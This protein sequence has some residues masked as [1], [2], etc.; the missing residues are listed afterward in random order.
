V[1]RVSEFYGIAIYMYLDEHPPPHFHARYGGKW[2]K[3]SIE[4]GR[5]IAG[6]LPGR[7][8]RFVR[9]WAEERRGDL[10]LNWRRARSGEP[11]KRIEPLQ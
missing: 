9:T 5:P 3:I 2:A 10:D 1:P 4:T 11:P 6:S 7:V 8:L